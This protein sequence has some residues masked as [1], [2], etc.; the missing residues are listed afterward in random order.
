MVDRPARAVG[1]RLGCSAASLGRGRHH[2]PSRW[3]RSATLLLVQTSFLLLAGRQFT[4]PAFAESAGWYTIDTG[5]AAIEFSVEHLHLFTYYGVF[6]RFWGHLLF[7]RKVPEKSHVNIVIDA[8]SVDMESAYA[9]ALLRS[10]QFFDVDQF[11]R[12]RFVSTA[13]TSIAPHHYRIQGTLQIR[14]IARPETLNVRITDRRSHN[15]DDSLDIVARGSVSRS[16]FGMS[17]DEM[18]ISDDVDLLIRAHLPQGK[19]FE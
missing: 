5:S 6:H 16:A 12:I 14:G 15:Q 10:P 3:S 2:S 9:L 13:I 17:A 7:D 8:T 1:C 11:R 19:T 18:Y 4:P